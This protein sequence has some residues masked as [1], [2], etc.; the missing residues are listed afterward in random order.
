MEIEKRTPAERKAEMEL[1]K[2][3]RG[4]WG[5]AS[6]LSWVHKPNESGKRTKP[7]PR[8]DELDK[9]KLAEDLRSMAR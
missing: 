5:N 9:C 8:L 2:E 7:A 3:L 1:E 6:T 4:G